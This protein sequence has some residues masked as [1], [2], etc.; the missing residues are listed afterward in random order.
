MTS[1]GLNPVLIGSKEAEAA[2]RLS[3]ETFA[4]AEGGH[5]SPQGAAEKPDS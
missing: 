1:M 3:R 2:A 5:C 4:A